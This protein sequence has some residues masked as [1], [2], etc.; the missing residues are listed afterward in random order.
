LHIPLQL[1]HPGWDHQI[2]GFMGCDCHIDQLHRDL[3]QFLGFGELF[4]RRWAGVQKHWT[5]VALAYNLVALRAVQHRHRRS[6]RQAL[7]AYRESMRPEELVH[8]L[9]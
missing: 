3:K 9:L 8:C 5:L 1:E 7:R 6:F 2:D 4:V